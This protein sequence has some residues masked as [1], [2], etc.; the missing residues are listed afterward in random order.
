MSS[1]GKALLCELSGSRKGKLITIRAISQWKRNEVFVS[2]YL[3]TPSNRSGPGISQCCCISKLIALIGRGQYRALG[4]NVKAVWPASLPGWCRG[5]ISSP[6]FSKMY[7][8]GNQ[9]PP[10]KLKWILPG[11][12]MIHSVASVRVTQGYRHPA[13][14]ESLLFLYQTRK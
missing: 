13:N 8:E 12:G 1:K 3:C 5:E 11:S 4:W 2:L 10:V 7:A 6:G 9:S 14:R